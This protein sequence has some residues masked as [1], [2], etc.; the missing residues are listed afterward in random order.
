MRDSWATTIKNR[1]CLQTGCPKFNYAS[2]FIVP[3]ILD[4]H[5]SGSTIK[6]RAIPNLWFMKLT[7]YAQHPK[8]LADRADHLLALHF[9]RPHS[10]H[11][12]VRGD[13]WYSVGGCWL[14][15]RA[16]MRCW[17]DLGCP[18]SSTR[19]EWAKVAAWCAGECLEA[20]A[21]TKTEKTVLKVVKS[22]P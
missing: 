6:S 16:S 5:C 4:K 11:L 9:W 18:T 17:E 13:Q 15:A 22:G 12:T 21:A 19:M 1:V 10:S 7:H 8:G 20:S 2:C 14:V 3:P